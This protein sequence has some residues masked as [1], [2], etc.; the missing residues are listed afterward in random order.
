VRN[1]RAPRQTRRAYER[2]SASPF[3][4]GDEDLQASRERSWQPWNPPQGAWGEGD[5]I[6]DGQIWNQSATKSLHYIGTV[7]HASKT[8]SLFFP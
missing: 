5:V 4:R 6:A 1:R 7:R 8:D 2:Q 3:R